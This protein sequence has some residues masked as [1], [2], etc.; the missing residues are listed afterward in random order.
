MKAPSIRDTDVLV[1]GAGP[2]GL[3][4]SLWLTRLGARV[5]I[6]D[7]IGEPETT[8]RAV[9]VQA[10][11]LELYSQIGLADA[12]VEHGRKAVAANIWVAG[13]KV[14]RAAFGEMGIGV[15]PFPYALIFPQDEHERL[16]ID[17]LAKAGVTVER[18]TQLADFQEA[19]GRVRALL[20]ASD[21][22]EETC[23]AAFLAGCDGARSAVRETLA[24]GFPGGTYAHL[25]YVADVEG[26]GP[27]MNGEVHVALDTTDFLAVFPLKEEGRARL[28]GTVRGEA[29]QQH[30]HLSWDDVSKRV[31]EWMH[32]NV[33]R[34]RWFSTYRVHHRVADHFR[35]GR[36]FL[37]GDAAHIHSP[38]GG[39]GMN[40]GIGDAVNLAW[41]LAAVLKGCADPS[42]LDSYEPERIAFARGLVATTDRVFTG[43]TSPGAIARWLRLDV[44][45]FLIPLVFKHAWARRFMFRT[46]SQ[47]ALNYRDSSLSEGRAKGVRGGDRLPWVEAG[48]K[49]VRADNF[50]P[51]TSLD[52]QVHVYGEAGSEIKAV[53]E[54]RQLLL[55]VFPWRAEMGR[56][57]L[58]RNSAYLVRPDGYLAVVSPGGRAAEVAS[59]LDA[60]KLTPRSK[61]GGS[62]ADG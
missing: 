21:G 34:V 46:I 25:F 11:T 17:R 60:H 50:T 45:P 9:A 58:L 52:W 18:Q 57:G 1:V 35:K 54:G 10:R 49:G 48:V 41:K 59:F 8:S 40:T 2:T 30:D 31:V 61:N 44:V 15:S 3:S 28:V 19:D 27:A 16:L 22:S 29:E 5:R 39:Q 6:V 20:K 12:V 37:L 24:I 38:V 47:T 32:I 14:A 7:K 36:V 62:A 42:L 23:E 43:V 55:H 51:L 13:K 53:C 4:L 26:G 56:A 33:E